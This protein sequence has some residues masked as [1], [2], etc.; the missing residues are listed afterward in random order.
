MDER[1]NGI[2]FYGIERFG[3]IDF[4]SIYSLLC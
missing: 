3:E 1:G 4:Y 2:L